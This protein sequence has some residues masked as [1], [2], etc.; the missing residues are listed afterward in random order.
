MGSALACLDGDHPITSIIAVPFDVD[1]V[2]TQ[3]QAAFFN[4]GICCAS[5]FYL[6]EVIKNQ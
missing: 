2:D 3:Y 1:L 6:D 4:T 5:K